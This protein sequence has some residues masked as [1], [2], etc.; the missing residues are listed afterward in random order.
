MLQQREVPSLLTWMASFVTYV[1]IVAEK[2]PEKI[3]PLL[4]YM[5]LLIR[6]AQHHGGKGRVNYDYIF[7]SITATDETT[8]WSQLDP[9]LLASFFTGQQSS[10]PTVTCTYCHEVDHGTWECALT[11]I[12]AQKVAPFTS[13]LPPTQPRQL[14]PTR[15]QRST[16]ICISWNKEKCML[17]GTCTFRYI[18]AGCHAVNHMAK[19][20]EQVPPDSPYRRQQTPAKLPWLGDRCLPIYFEGPMPLVFSE[21]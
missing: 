12:Q 14:P 2:W 1:A 9:S 8:D 18:C 19:D 21:G 15:E 20:C 7:R 5:R 4:A 3:K 13:P 16:R 10:V 6:E 17:P 11:P